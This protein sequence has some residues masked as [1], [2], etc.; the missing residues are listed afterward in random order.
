MRVFLKGISCDWHNDDDVGDAVGNEIFPQCYKVA[1]VDVA[2]R[3]KHDGAT[4]MGRFFFNE[5]F[6]ERC[7]LY[8]IAVEFECTVLVHDNVNASFTGISFFDSR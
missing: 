6:D 3:L 8:R 4:F 7:F 2:F 5:A 1:S